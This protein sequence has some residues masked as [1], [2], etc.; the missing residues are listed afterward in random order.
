MYSTLKISLFFLLLSIPNFAQQE[1]DI[2]GK[3]LLPNNLEIEV[4]KEN[5]Y[6]SAKIIALNNYKEG[7]TKDCKNTDKSKRNELL[8]GKIVL[9]HLI[10]DSTTK[11][12][13]NGKMYAPDKGVTV[14]LKVTKINEKEATVV[15]S[16]YFF[17]KTIT[18]KKITN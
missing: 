1:D 3:Y 11:Q 6:F 10:F 7:Q 2:I 4:Y 14:N 15:G 9:T 17:W 16:K 13:K 8:L 12:W 18:W 5:Q